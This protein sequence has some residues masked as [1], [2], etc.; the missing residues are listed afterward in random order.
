MKLIITLLF[1]SLGSLSYGQNDAETTCN[2]D[3]YRD[4]IYTPGNHQCD[5]R[6]ANLSRADFFRGANFSYANLFRANFSYANLRSTNLTRAKLWGGEV[7]RGGFVQSEFDL[8]E[9][10]RGGFARCEFGRGEF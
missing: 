3:N 7:A 8:G 6:D 2:I 4:Y 9:V 10:A 1:L 5:L